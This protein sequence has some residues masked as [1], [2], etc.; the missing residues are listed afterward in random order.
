MVNNN[1]EVVHVVKTGLFCYNNTYNLMDIMRGNMN[2][3][4][5]PN[6]NSR[7]QYESGARIKCHLGI[8]PRESV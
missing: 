4:H 1:N 2:K 3:C 5:I 8:F 7:G 6:E